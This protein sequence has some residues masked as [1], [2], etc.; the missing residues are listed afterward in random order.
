MMELP[1]NI[2]RIAVFAGIIVLMLM[3]M[4]FNTRLESLN[5]LNRELGEK[6]AEATQAAQTEA[7]LQTQVAFAT[8]DQA[9]EEWARE[10]GH[11]KQEGDQPVVPMGQPG[12]ENPVVE[13]TPT[14]MPT[15]MQNWEVWR[16]L[17]FGRK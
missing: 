16:D 13:L 15:P 3:V 17:F 1:L 9:V 12:G 2:K 5:R 11:Y 7:Y 8:S 6:R 10:D 14:P 4:D